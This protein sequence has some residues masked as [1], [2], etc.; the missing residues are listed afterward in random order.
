MFWVIM[1]TNSQKNVDKSIK[2]LAEEINV[3][4]PQMHLWCGTT[5]LYSQSEL[6]ELVFDLWVEFQERWLRAKAISNIL[7]ETHTRTRTLCARSLGKLLLGCYYTRHNPQ[8]HRI[9]ACFQN[10]SWQFYLNPFLTF[11]FILLIYR[12]TTVTF[13]RKVSRAYNLL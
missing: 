11:T 6:V 1:L 7:Q 9:I 4:I 12:W 10:V 5:N 3:Y 2:S 8:Y 13:T